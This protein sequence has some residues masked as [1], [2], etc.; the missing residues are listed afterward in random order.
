VQ[1]EASTP[2]RLEKPVLKDMT[3]GTL[4]GLRHPPDCDGPTTLYGFRLSHQRPPPTDLVTALQRLL[5]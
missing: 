2:P 4:L 3:L 1:P 5:I